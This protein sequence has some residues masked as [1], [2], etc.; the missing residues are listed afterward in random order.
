MFDQSFCPGGG[1]IALDGSSDS[2][3]L[4]GRL[5][6]PKFVCWKLG[7]VLGLGLLELEDLRA[8][9]GN[10]CGGV[11]LCDCMLVAIGFIDR[12]ALFAL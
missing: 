9:S 2:E 5:K 1:N 4:R 3:V 8:I 12:S 6:A 7:D 10:R 11:G